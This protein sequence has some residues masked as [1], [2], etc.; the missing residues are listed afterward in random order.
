[1]WFQLSFCMNSWFLEPHF[2]LLFHSSFFIVTHEWFY[3]GCSCVAT[4]TISVKIPKK[5]Q[6]E[7]FENLGMLT[8]L[9]CNK[10]AQ[11]PCPGKPPLIEVLGNEIEVKNILIH[12]PYTVLLHVL[13]MI[14]RIKR[15]RQQFCCEAVG[16]PVE[17]WA[18]CHLW[19]TGSK[20]H[21]LPVK[22]ML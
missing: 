16:L 21:D 18:S 5:I 4:G 19:G 1:M 20:L 10:K 12:S 2:C 7:N 15:R 9:L 22:F 11:N 3:S 17:C 13:L 8:T 14:Y 6:G